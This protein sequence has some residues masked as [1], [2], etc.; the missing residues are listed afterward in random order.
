[1]N[2]YNIQWKKSGYKNFHLL[3][4][5]TNNTVNVTAR[6]TYSLFDL[7]GDLGGLYEFFLIAGGLVI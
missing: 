1:M 6:E 5:S 2:S 3:M 4:V 7:F